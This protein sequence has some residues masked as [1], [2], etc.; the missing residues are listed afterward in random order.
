MMTRYHK[1]A[2]EKERLV[3]RDKDTEAHRGTQR[4]T[5]SL[6]HSHTHTLTH[7][8][9]HTLTPATCGCSRASQHNSVAEQK[10]VFLSNLSACELAL[11]R[12]QDAI[13]HSTM[14]IDLDPSNTKLL[15]RRAKV[16]PLLPPCPFIVPHFARK[17]SHIAHPHA[18]F[19]CMCV[20]ACVCVCAC[21]GVGGGVAAGPF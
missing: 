3:E 8:H 15:Y 10:P 9:T 14:G 5:H 6:T 19:A 1:Q 12:H 7:S 21:W 13:L 18:L 11:G 4:L 16:G 2:K 17:P 20:C